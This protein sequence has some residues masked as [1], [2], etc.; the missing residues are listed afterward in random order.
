MA[1]YVITHLI[2]N[3]CHLANGTYIFIYFE[4][5]KQLFYSGIA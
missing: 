1:A 4:S 2:Q 3:M 5:Y